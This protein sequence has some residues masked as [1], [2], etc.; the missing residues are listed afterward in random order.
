MIFSPAS[1]ASSRRT[2][3][4]P[5]AARR[6]PPATAL[7]IYLEVFGYEDSG[8]KRPPS[9]GRRSERIWSEF[10]VAAANKPAALLSQPTKA[11]AGFL[12]SVWRIS[13]RRRCAARSFYNRS[14]QDSGWSYWHELG[15]K[16]LEDT[17]GSRGETVCRECVAQ[18]DAQ[19]VIER[20]IEDG[21]DVILPSPPF[22]GR[23]HPSVCHPPE[24]QNPQLL[25][26]GQLPTMSAA[27]TCACTRPIYLW[28]DCRRPVGKRRNRLHRGLPHL[29]H[30]HVDQCLSPSARRWSN[31]RAQIVLEWSTLPGQPGG[32]AAR[33]VHIISSRDISA[34]HLESARVRPVSRAGRRDL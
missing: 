11:A 8:R 1:T 27:T 26:A 30:A 20:F 32:G 21:Y 9:S 25:A 17:L 2:T 6:C 13:R 12:Q 24:R 14:P 33:G 22:F 15:R 3:P 16:A 5:K 4:R 29:R 28:R 7:L 34:P 18:E 10:V 19:E 31:P 23:L